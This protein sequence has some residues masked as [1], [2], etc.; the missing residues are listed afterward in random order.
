MGRSYTIHHLDDANLCRALRKEG[1]P[2]KVI[3]EKMEIPISTVWHLCNTQ[4]DIGRPGNLAQPS[5]HP[6]FDTPREVVTKCRTMRV[7]GMT[8][9]AIAN[10]L[11]ISASAVWN[12]CNKGDGSN[13]QKNETALQG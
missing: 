6:C 10:A 8:Y 5:R 11:N 13:R 2:Y 7:K 12:I 9:Q 1:L 3:A 4:R